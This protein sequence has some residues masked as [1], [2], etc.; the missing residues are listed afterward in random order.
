[1]IREAVGAIVFKNDQFLIIKKTK[2]NTLAGTEI[3]GSEW[4]FI[5]GG[6]ME[7]DISELNWL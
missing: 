1:M 5:K 3:I 6:V 4:D 2:I 7:S